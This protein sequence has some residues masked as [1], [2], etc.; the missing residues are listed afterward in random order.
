[1]CPSSC[2]PGAWNSPFLTKWSLPPST[3]GKH[4]FIIWSA[5]ECLGGEVVKEVIFS[6]RACA[7]SV[8]TP[9]FLWVFHLFLDVCIGFLETC[10]IDSHDRSR[11]QEAGALT[12]TGAS[13]THTC[14]KASEN[15]AG[16]VIYNFLSQLPIP[17]SFRPQS[18]PSWFRFLVERP[19]PLLLKELDLVVL[20]ALGGSNLPLMIPWS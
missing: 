3:F 1:M 14:P 12:L 10:H 13:T 17:C 19:K 2:Q 16:V 4:Y 6:G 18:A 9:P 8:P 7:A 15:K 20:P 11:G 5:Q